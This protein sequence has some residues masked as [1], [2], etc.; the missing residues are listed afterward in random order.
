[1]VKAWGSVQ[2]PPAWPRKTSVLNSRPY[3]GPLKVPITDMKRRLGF[4][5]VTCQKIGTRDSKG[6]I[7]KGTSEADI[8]L[9]ACNNRQELSVL[10]EGFEDVYEWKIEK[11]S[12]T[13]ALDGSF[14]KFLEANTDYKFPKEITYDHYVTVNPPEEGETEDEIRQKLQTLNSALQYRSEIVA[15]RQLVEAPL[16]RKVIEL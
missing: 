14:E 9:A 2:V 15:L 13:D 5:K 16:E 3:K 6:R 12:C 1:M 4:C 10:T 8:P 7:F 11:I